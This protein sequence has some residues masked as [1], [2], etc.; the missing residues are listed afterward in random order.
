[1]FRATL[2]ALL[3]GVP[4][5]I[6]LDVFAHGRCYGRPAAA[7]AIDEIMKYCVGDDRLWVTTREQIADCAHSALK[8]DA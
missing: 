2:D 3:S 6:V 8:V 1:M 7:W 5:T 4:E